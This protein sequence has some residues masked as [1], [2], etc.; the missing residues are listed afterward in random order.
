MQSH[1]IAGLL[2]PRI[3]LGIPF[4]VISKVLSTLVSDI[5]PDNKRSEALSYFV[6][7]VTMITAALGA[8][9]GLSVLRVCSIIAAHSQ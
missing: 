3:F 4:V 8:S 6:I 2:E 9:L 5:N 1:N 7:L